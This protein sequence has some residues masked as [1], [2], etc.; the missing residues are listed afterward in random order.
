MH[1]KDTRCLVEVLFFVFIPKIDTKNWLLEAVALERCILV[2]QVIMKAPVKERLP[3]KGPVIEVM[4]EVSETEVE[5][6]FRFILGGDRG[7]VF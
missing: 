2:L 4:K 1:L 5:A 3:H 7:V 6:V